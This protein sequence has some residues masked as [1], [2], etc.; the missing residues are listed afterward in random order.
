M[1]RESRIAAR[2]GRIQGLNRP[3]ITLVACKEGTTTFEFFHHESCFF[4]FE[5]WLTQGGGLGGSPHEP[6]KIAVEK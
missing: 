2:A 5:Q 4:R 6:E 1:G 3:S